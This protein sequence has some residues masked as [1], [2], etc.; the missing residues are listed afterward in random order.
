MD[1]QIVSRKIRRHYNKLLPGTI[2]YLTLLK[3]EYKWI[4]DVVEAQEQLRGYKRRLTKES[5][6]RLGE[7][8]RRLE[9]MSQV[10][11]HHVLKKEKFERKVQVRKKRVKLSTWWS[12]AGIVVQLRPP[13]WCLSVENKGSATRLTTPLWELHY[14][15][16]H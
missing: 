9:L 13:R 8:R 3:L 10:Q 4:N 1:E 2:S 6:A 15:L 12:A 11:P 14:H 16:S 7:L 5:N